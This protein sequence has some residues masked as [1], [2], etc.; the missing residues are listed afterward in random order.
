MSLWY[1]LI[2]PFFYIWLYSIFIPLFDFSFFSM[3]HNYISLNSILICPPH[4]D[5]Y[6]NL[7]LECSAVYTAV[8]TAHEHRKTQEMCLVSE[9]LG[10]LLRR[11][12]CQFYCI[13]LQKVVT[14]TRVGSSYWNICIKTN[15][16]RDRIYILYS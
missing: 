7:R 16:C 13:S 5:Y 9:V 4:V 8:R 1:D 11:Y 12:R 15:V 3:A 10:L 14:L 2:S 6:R